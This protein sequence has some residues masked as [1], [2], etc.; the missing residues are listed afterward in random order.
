MG[1]GATGAGVSC[2]PRQPDQTAASAMSIK[3]VTV[4]RIRASYANE[5]TVEW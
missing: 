5:E 2:K 4:G 3:T 1:S